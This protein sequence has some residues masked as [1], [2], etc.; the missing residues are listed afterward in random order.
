MRL[1]LY[2][3]SGSNMSPNMPSVS[4]FW[5]IESREGLSRQRK[6]V[7]QKSEHCTHFYLD[8]SEMHVQVIVQLLHDGAEFKFKE[9]EINSW[10]VSMKD[11]EEIE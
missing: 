5:P 8:I 4:L 3:C 6:D 9:C 10:N 11:K 2:A 7:I 1:D